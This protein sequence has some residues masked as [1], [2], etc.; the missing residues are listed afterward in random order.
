MLWD[1]TVSELQKTVQFVDNEAH[2]LKGFLRFSQRGTVLAA[3]I[4]PKNS[5]LPRLAPHF[6]ERL[7][8]ERY[9]PPDGFD[10]PAGEMRDRSR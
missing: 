1:S 5:V 8:E 6:S 10:P 7:P 9:H 4:S 3:T 2:L